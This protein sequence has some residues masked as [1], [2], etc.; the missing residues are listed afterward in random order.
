M[1][2]KV[3]MFAKGDLVHIAEDLG[4]S[5]AHFT[6]GVD[7]I[8]IGSYNDKFGGGDT[9]SYTLYINGHGSVAW[10]Y[11]HQLTL[12]AKDQLHLLTQ[13]KAAADALAKQVSDLDWIFQNGA[14]VLKQTHGSTVAAL[15]AEMG[16][17][18]LWGS[19]G[20]GFT[21]YENARGILAFAH[22]YLTTGNKEGWLA[23]AAKFKETLLLKAG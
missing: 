14:A 6:S 10:Y 12:I 16:I 3:Q 18:N 5:M 21:Y 7:A 9:K 11:E 4:S 23:A 17:T 8:V 1:S 20:E 19:R 2:T 13:W 22:P 15:G